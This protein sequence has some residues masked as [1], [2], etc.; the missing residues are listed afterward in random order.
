MTHPRPSHPSPAPA[1][2]T[3]YSVHRFGAKG[4]GKADDT[5]A[6]QKAIDAEAEAGG[7]GVWFPPGR[8]MTAMLRLRPYV[9]L[10]AHPTWSY[11]NFG[12]TRL[13]L[14]DPQ[15]PQLIDITAAYGVRISGLGLD[16]QNLGQGV[17]GIFLDGQTH[18]QEETLF[19]EHCRVSGFTGDA[20]HLFCVWGFTVRSNMFIFNK[21]DGLNFNRC[22]GWIND[23]IFNNNEGWGIHARPWN[24]ALTILGNRIEWNQAGGVRLGASGMVSLN[25]NY[26]DRSGGPGIRLD[27]GNE[28]D[29]TY[30]RR[31]SVSISGNVIHRSGARVPLE[32]HDNCHIWLEHQ[33]GVVCSGNTMTTGV[34]DGGNGQHSPSYGIVYQSLR[35]CV[36]KDNTFEMGVR[37]QFLVDLGDNDA[38]VII[39]DNVGSLAGDEVRTF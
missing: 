20:A 3:P 24:G 8:Y 27:P 12:G 32:S 34:N 17:R 28:V 26:I 2:D 9:G 36:I 10:F 5:A 7:G 19:I 16:G 13:A 21:G 1:S 31:R 29:R 38:S 33:A 23:N 35:N 14:L 4:D 22:D 15:A 30:G 6:I 25:D 39:K 11:H 37:R 18:N